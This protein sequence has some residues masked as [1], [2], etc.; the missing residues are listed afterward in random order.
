MRKSR[1]WSRNF[2]G[3]LHQQNTRQKKISDIENAVEGS[4]N[5]ENIKSKTKYRHK[6]LRKYYEKPKYTNKRKRNQKM[7]KKQKQIERPTC[8]DIQE[9]HIN[10]ELEATI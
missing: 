1:N 7:Y 8:L 10:T 5:K 2:R 6:K 9:S 4:R 3:K